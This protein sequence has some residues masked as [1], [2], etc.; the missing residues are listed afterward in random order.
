[1]GQN[2]THV[3]FHMSMR[4]LGGGVQLGSWESESSAERTGRG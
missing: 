2:E 4:Y 3:T 1:M